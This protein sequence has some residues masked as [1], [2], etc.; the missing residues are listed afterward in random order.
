MLP[1]GA[2]K[3]P[4]NLTLTGY[5]ELV[6]ERLQKLLLHRLGEVLHSL[7]QRFLLAS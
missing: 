5:L 7:S 3:S 2:S 1:S 6:G 4:Q